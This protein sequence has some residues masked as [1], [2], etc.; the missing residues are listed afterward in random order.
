MILCEKQKANVIEDD[1]V[2]NFLSAPRTY[3]VRPH[4][5]PEMWP[6]QLGGS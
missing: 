1:Q 6:M 5:I 3:Q 4:R 2:D